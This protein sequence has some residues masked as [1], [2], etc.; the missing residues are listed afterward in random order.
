M[1]AAAHLLKSLGIP[2]SRTWRRSSPHQVHTDRLVHFDKPDPQFYFTIDCDWVPGSQRG[3]ERLLDLCDRLR[4]KSTIFFAGRFAETYP[5]LVRECLMRGH[6]LGT[7]G[8]AHG[9]LEADED[10]RYA[11]YAQQREWIRLATDAVERA[12]GIRPIIFRAPNL[13]ISETTFQALEAEGYRYDSSI[14]ARRFDMGLGRVHYTK[15]FWAPLEPYH[16]LPHDLAQAGG[17]SI[18]EIAPSSCLFPLNLALLRTLRLPLLQRMIHWVERRSRHL[19]FYCHPFEFVRPAHQ[20]FPQSMSKWNQWGMRP[21][22]LVL[23][24]QLLEHIIQRGFQPARMT[25]ADD[26]HLDLKQA[27]V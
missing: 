9:G 1:R 22:N 3:L 26:R 17:C 19:V 21:E 7:H 15:Y 5:A 16:P 2:R 4:L 25:E 12:A 20:H 24:E 14:P 11:S 10:F 18:I 27:V 23:L 6:L 8:W 13:W